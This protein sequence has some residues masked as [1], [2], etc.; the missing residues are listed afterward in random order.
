MNIPPASRADGPAQALEDQLER[1]PA[2]PGVY[3]MIDAGRQVLYVG[4]AVDLRSRVRSYFQS[5]RVHQWRTDAMVERV[6]EIRTIIVKNEVEALLLE[7]NLIKQHKPPFNV[8]LKDDKK[9]PFLKVT[10]GEPFP[11]V[12]FTRTVVQDGGRYYGPFT[13][14]GVLRDSIELIRRVFPLR[15]CKQDIGIKYRRPCL[16]YHIKRCMAP[17]A[18]L[19]TEQEYNAIVGDVLLFL[20]GRHDVLV[21]RLE[22]Q[23][24]QA[25]EGL[26]FEHAGRLR[27]RIADLKRVMARQEVVWR[28]QIDMDLIAGAHGQGVSAVEIFFVRGGKLIGQEHFIVEGTQG[29]DPGH[30]FSQFLAQFYAQGA[31]IPKEIMVETAIADAPENERALSGMRGNRVRIVVP[32]RGQRADYMRKVK[33]NAEQHLADFLSKTSVAAERAAL[34]LEELAAGLNLPALPQRIECFDIS[35]VQ[36]T[37]VVGSM[38]VFEDG[39]PS[40]SEYRRFKIQGAEKND[41]F[42][43][44]AQMLRRRLR[45]LDPNQ[46]AGGA[47][48]GREKKFAR[49]PSLLLIDGGRGQLSAIG[50]V[51]R[52]MDLV[53][54]PVVAL[55]KQFEEVYLPDEAEPVLFARNSPALH[56]IQRIRDEAH[57]FAVTYHR[58]LRGK[59]QVASALDDLRGVGPARRK[60]LVEKFGSASAVRRASVSQLET[61]PGISPALARSIHDSLQDPTIDLAVQGR[62]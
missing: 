62:D 2:E 8:R 41:D 44:M 20:E 6:V 43:N 50:D 61:V 12:I 57:R 60:T 23:M 52:E 36:G 31:R 54:L 16:Q 28:S 27:D 58:T 53:A 47:M 37:N 45:Y 17:C 32:W 48:P 49:R 24:R 19:Q 35:H 25:S 42:A 7:C 5:S 40:K 21:R 56:L 11:R 38:V 15:T 14:A 4:K 1:L 46:A 18:F 10:L 51:L 30:I 33:R 39:C 34:A 13:N 55:A 26:A 59:G 9:Y 29:R 22:G 3:Q